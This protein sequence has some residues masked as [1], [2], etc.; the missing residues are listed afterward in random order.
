MSEPS[1]AAK[2]HWSSTFWLT[3]FILLLWFIFAFVVHWY[4]N[5]L[6]TMSFMGFPLGYYLAVQGS[7]AIFVVLIFVQNW[8]QDAIDSANGFDGSEES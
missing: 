5:E 1:E 3:V 8:I 6:N 4:A 2:R 7:L